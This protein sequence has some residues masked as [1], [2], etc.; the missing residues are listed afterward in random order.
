M[1]VHV[2]IPDAKDQEVEVSLDYTMRPMKWGRGVGGERGRR[3][4]RRKMREE[5]GKSS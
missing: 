1:V 4:G 3:R 5:K 2:Y